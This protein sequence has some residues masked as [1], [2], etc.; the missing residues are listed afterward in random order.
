MDI[1]N[2]KVA[3]ITGMNELPNFIGVTSS[4]VDTEPHNNAVMV[5]G[6]LVE[7][8][9]NDAVMNDVG[10]EYVWANGQWNLYSKASSE[11]EI[12]YTVKGGS[13]TDPELKQVLARARAMK[14]CVHVNIK[15]EDGWLDVDYEIASIERIRRIAKPVVQK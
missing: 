7:A 13:I 9:L 15:V 3:A 14:G 12:T 5:Y 6:R 2:N 10:D 1:R 11:R 4:P 8:S